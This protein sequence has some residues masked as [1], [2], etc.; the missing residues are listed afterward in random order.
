MRQRAELT[1]ALI[2]RAWDAWQAGRL[3]RLDGKDLR[4]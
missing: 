1:A 3:K 4:A 2:L